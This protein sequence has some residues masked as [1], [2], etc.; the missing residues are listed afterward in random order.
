[1]EIK[2]IQDLS[3]IGFGALEQVRELL[4][5]IGEVSGHSLGVDFTPGAV[6]ITH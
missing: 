4:D 5:A 3:G 6:S 2:I 1:V